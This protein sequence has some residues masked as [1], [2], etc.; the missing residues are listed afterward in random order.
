MMLAGNLPSDTTLSPSHLPSTDFTKLPDIFSFVCLLIITDSLPTL[1]PSIFIPP[2]PHLI[3]LSAI[4]F[5]LRGLR[6]TQIGSFAGL[7][8]VPHPSY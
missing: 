4:V 8:A 2:V 3:T 7:R 6:A 1:H 5:S